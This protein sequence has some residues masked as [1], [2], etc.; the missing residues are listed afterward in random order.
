MLIVLVAP[1]LT[2]VAG[3]ILFRFIDRVPGDR[4]GAWLTPLLALGCA[5][6]YMWYEAAIVS[7]PGSVSGP[8]LPVFAVI[9][10][11]LHP[12][13]ILTPFPLFRKRLSSVNPS[14]VVAATVFVVVAVVALLNFSGGDIRYIPPEGLAGWGR[15]IARTALVDLGLATVVYAGFSALVQAGGRCHSSSFPPKKEM[16]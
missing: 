11:C 13:W 16:E 7:D 4:T 1:L 5:G 14:I 9:G 8:L 2:A 12:L 15:E 10:I 6:A 3:V